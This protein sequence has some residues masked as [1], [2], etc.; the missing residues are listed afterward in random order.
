VGPLTFYLTP[1]EVN[2]SVNAAPNGSFVLSTCVL[3]SLTIIS[4]LTL[5]NRSER[6]SANSFRKSAY[7]ALE[8]YIVTK[9]CNME[10]AKI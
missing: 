2:K 3:K 6:K 4:L 8:V 1:N 10:S 5:T 9:A 7:R